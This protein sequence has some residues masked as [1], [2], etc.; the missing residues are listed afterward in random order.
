[1]AVQDGDG[2]PR[3]RADRERARGRRGRR[4][5]TRSP[6]EADR[7]ADR[8]RGRAPDPPLPGRGGRAVAV[9]DVDAGG[10]P[11]AGDRPVRAL[12]ARAPARRRARDRALHRRR[13]A[14]RGRDG[15]AGV[16]LGSRLAAELYGCR[17]LAENVED[18]PD[19]VTRFV[20]LAPAGEAERARAGDAKTSIVFWGGGDQSPG[21]L[22]EVLRRVR[23]PRREPDPDRVAAA[24]DAGSATT[25]SSPTSRARP[26]SRP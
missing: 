24:P 15:D 5:S 1:M 16:A 9:D 14:V 22:V 10:L 8:R 3:R 21:W 12:P 26:A 4:R 11:P 18:H 25:C 13:G 17:V 19:N 6:R 2:R 7:R 23:G 20:W